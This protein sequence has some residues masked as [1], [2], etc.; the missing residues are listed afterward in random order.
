MNRSLLVYSLSSWGLE[1]RLSY[2]IELLCP[3]RFANSLL[4]IDVEDLRNK[5]FESVL[6]DLDNTLLP[7]K[8]SIVPKPVVAWIEQAKSTG[9]K[10]CI[11]SNTHNPKRLTEIA[12]NLGI[13]CIHRALKPRRQGFERASRMLGCDP[14]QTVVVG[15]QIVTDILG[16]NLAGMYT[17]LVKPMHKQEFV[18][19]KLSRLIERMI[20]HLLARQSQQGTNFKTNQSQTQDTR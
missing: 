13:P 17:I 14:K 9:M 18:G 10:L 7:W 11:V 19:T 8:D 16:G 1:V 12:A 20:L 15:D 3:D 5:G 2:F 6:L 4:D